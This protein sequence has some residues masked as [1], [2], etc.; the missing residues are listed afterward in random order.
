MQEMGVRRIIAISAGGIYDELPEPFNTWDL[1]MVGYT[2]P[3][4]LKTADVIENS[5]LDYTVLRP[6][7]LTNHS[8]TE[9]Q[10]TKKGEMFSDAREVLPGP[11]VDTHFQWMRGLFETS[12][13]RP[14]CADRQTLMHIWRAGP[15]ARAEQGSWGNKRANRPRPCAY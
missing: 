9:F 2:R 5:S 6:V 1:D 13:P 11:A 8:T 3:I 12:I 7:W 10:L 14:P 15:A 4:N